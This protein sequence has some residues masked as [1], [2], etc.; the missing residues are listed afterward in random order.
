MMI[1]SRMVDFLSLGI[2]WE[3]SISCEALWMNMVMAFLE[4]ETGR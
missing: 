3:I 1:H 4:L 2:V